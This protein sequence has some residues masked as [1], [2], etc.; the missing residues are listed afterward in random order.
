MRSIIFAVAATAILINPDKSAR[1]AEPDPVATFAAS[2]GSQSKCAMVLPTA[3]QNTR[4]SN[5]IGAI[6]QYQ[7]SDGKPY[8]AETENPTQ[9]V[10]ML[11]SKPWCAPKS[12]PLPGVADY[13]GGGVVDLR[14]NVLDAGVD[15]NVSLGKIFNL[16]DLTASYVNAVAY[17]VDDLQYFLADSGDQKDA[18]RSII[19]R[20]EDCEESLA[21]PKSQM[22]YRICTGTIKLGVYYKREV[23]GS[24]VDLTLSALKVNFDVHFLEQLSSVKPCKDGAPTAPAKPAAAATPAPKAGAAATPTPAATTVTPEAVGAAVAAA[25]TA[26]SKNQQPAAAAT[27]KPAETP[28]KAA[29]TTPDPQKCYDIAYFTSSPNAVIG[30]RLSPTGTGEGSVAALVKALPKSPVPAHQ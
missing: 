4:S 24:L 10:T 20:G 9:I 19:S 3:T 23:K 25:L 5:R 12:W 2:F 11:E 17:G 21:S 22:A 6:A 26:L 18:A 30:V 7:T 8:D 16:V 29:A 27:P 28:A 1:A 13:Q 14:Q 15:F